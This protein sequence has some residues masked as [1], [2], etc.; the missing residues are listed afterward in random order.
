M[1]YIRSPELI[2]EYK[3]RMNESVVEHKDL[4]HGIQCPQWLIDRME[5]LKKKPRPSDEEVRTF[6][7]AANRIQA[8][9]SIMYDSPPSSTLYYLEKYS[10][11]MH[12]KKKNN[13]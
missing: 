6:F 11:I 3:K 1:K 4:N 8:A 5:A 13:L 10:R 12:G 7:E 2:K 9:C